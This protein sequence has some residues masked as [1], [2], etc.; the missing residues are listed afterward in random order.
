MIDLPKKAMKKKVDL[1]EPPMF[2]LIKRAEKLGLSLREVLRMSG[3]NPALATTW[4]KNDIKTVNKWLDVVKSTR[5]DIPKPKVSTVSV[6][7]ENGIAA[8]PV[9]M[10]SGFD[11]ANYVRIWSKRDPR[12]IENYKRVHHKLLKLEKQNRYSNILT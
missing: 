4:Q 11:S 8:R 6:L 9:F 7:Q 1:G 12:V 5:I 2:S 10:K 3:L